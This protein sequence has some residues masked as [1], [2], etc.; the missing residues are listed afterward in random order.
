MPELPGPA[1]KPPR[2]KK[3]IPRGQFNVTLPDEV[4]EEVRAVCARADC[5]PRDLFLVAL[6]KVGL[7]TAVPYAEMHPSQLRKPRKFKK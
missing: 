5:L 4:I 3:G 2:V 7:K 1:P 6:A